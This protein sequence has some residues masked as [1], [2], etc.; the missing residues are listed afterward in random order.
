[1]EVTNGETD[2]FSLLMK[3]LS[4]VYG[5]A[6]IVAGNIFKQTS[7]HLNFWSCLWM[8][9]MGTTYLDIKLRSSSSCEETY[10]FMPCTA[11]AVENLFL[12]VVYGYLLFVSA[13]MMSNGSEL[14]LHVM[15]WGSMPSGRRM[16]SPRWASVLEERCIY[17]PR[18]ASTP[19]E[20]SCRRYPEEMSCKRYRL[21]ISSF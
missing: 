10:G 2:T 14:L 15:G 9:T 21:R 17:S 1:M 5:V 13:S 6:I 16:Y 20:I 7:V 8:C 12:M 4:V 3:S 19:E 11:S 18:W